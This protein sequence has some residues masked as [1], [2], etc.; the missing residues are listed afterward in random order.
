MKTLAIIT[1]RGGSK[2]IPRKNI[3]PFYGRP[4]IAY[5]IEAAINSGAF[6]KVMVSTDDEEIAEISRKYGAEVPFMRS[7]KTSGDFATTTDVLKEVLEEYEKRG[8]HFDT[9][10]CL[11]PTAPFITAERIREAVDKFRAS[12]ADTLISVTSFSYPPQRALIMQG[13]R[14]VFKYPEHLV[15]RSQ[16]LQKEYHDAGQFYV[17]DTDAFI[18]NKNL[19]LGNI[20]PLEL[21]E[22]EV[23]DID[24]EVDWELAELKY[25]LVNDR[26]NS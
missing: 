26:G 8:E 20:I 13:D 18:R 23:Q 6:D 21:S 12:E 3:K 25:K 10:C 4:I 15:T 14:L 17:F 9:A 16:D 24:T 1:A 19:M 11:Y 2:R 7:E 5:S 22:L